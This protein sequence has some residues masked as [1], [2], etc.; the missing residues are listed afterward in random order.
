MTAPVQDQTSNSDA[1][2][3]SIGQNYAPGRHQG[4]A[5]PVRYLVVVAATLF[6]TAAGILGV[7][8][9]LDIAGRKPPP[10]FTNSNRFDAKLEF[11]RDTPPIRPTHLVVESLMAWRNLAVET[12]TKQHPNAKPLNGAFCGLSMHQIAFTTCFLLKRFPTAT[13]VRLLLD[14]FDMSACRSKKTDIFDSADVSAYLS[15]ADDLS[16]YFSTSMSTRSSKT[17][18]ALNRCSPPNAPLDNH[19]LRDLVYG[20]A[21]IIQPACETALAAFA[22]DV[23]KSGK[24]LFV[25]TMPLLSDWS[26]KYDPGSS[27]KAQLASVIGR[28]LDGTSATFWDGWSKIVLPTEYYSD[29][30]HLQGKAVPGFTRQLVNLVSACNATFTSGK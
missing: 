15:G 25:V 18:L 23:E 22:T 11:L 1:S 4:T 6:F 16:F 27:A 26:D 20:P 17:H 7:L 8:W 10:A 28:A 12:V 21:P 24:R 5:D 19:E 3:L 13:D 30:T 2:R 29:A 9:G 14:P